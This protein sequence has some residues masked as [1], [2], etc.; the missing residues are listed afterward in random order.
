[1]RINTEK[2]NEIVRW[3]PC[4]STPVNR[5]SPVKHWSNSTFNNGV[6]FINK[7]KSSFHN[8]WNKTMYRMSIVISSW[9]LIKMIVTLVRTQHPVKWK[10]NI[11]FNT[12][13]HVNLNLRKNSISERSRGKISFTVFQTDLG[14]SSWIHWLFIC[15]SFKCWN[16]RFVVDDISFI[17][18]WRIERN[19][20]CHNFV[21][22]YGNWFEYTVKKTV[23]FDLERIS[24][25][26]WQ[27]IRW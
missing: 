24:F 4:E 3:H 9:N 21:F 23:G 6:L 8:G 1:M 18:S 12:S 26:Y 17:Y 27:P 20:G 25:S 2:T 19:F 22:S 7:S 5:C 13:K 16:A 11:N 15:D 10:I 14:K